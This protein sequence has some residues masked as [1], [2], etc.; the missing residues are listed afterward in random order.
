MMQQNN[1]FSRL[2]GEP[3]LARMTVDNLAKFARDCI[4][5]NR[6]VGSTYLARYARNSYHN[7][8]LFYAS[9]A[10][11]IQM[12]LN[13]SQTCSLRIPAPAVVVEGAVAA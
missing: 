9:D 4:R 5:N 10:K 11:A 1:A 3:Y 13:Y 8:E 2:V 7:A 12:L 6:R